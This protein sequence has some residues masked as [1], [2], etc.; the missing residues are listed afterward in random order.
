MTAALAVSERTSQKYIHNSTYK[1]Q[2]DLADLD[3]QAQE[4]MESLTAQMK[5]AQGITKAA[6]DGKRFR[7]DTENE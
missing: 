2:T 4:R 3:K 7:M 5:R 1:R 6:K